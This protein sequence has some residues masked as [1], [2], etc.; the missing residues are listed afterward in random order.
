MQPDHAVEGRLSP[1]GLVIPEG[2]KLDLKSL[3]LF[4]GCASFFSANV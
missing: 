3:R 4:N 2:T 1:L